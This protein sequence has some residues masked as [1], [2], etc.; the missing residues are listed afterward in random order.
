MTSDPEGLIPNRR[1]L[2]L[3]TSVVLNVLACGAPVC[4]LE[5]LQTRF[6]VP[7]QVVREI[8]KEPIGTDVPTDTFGELL[9]R[10]LLLEHRLEG[11][12]LRTFVELAAANPPDGLGD[13]EAAT[14][15]LAEDL[16][17]EAV[18]D[19]R[20]ATRIATFRR[21]HVPVLCTVDLFYDLHQ[22]LTARGH[23]VSDYVYKA[24]RDGRMRVPNRSGDWVV[25]LIGIKRA[26]QCP[27]LSSIVRSRND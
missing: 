6:I 8:S 5:S 7:S 14:I 25:N 18:I 9:R 24:L 11:D 23:D 27:S 26:R 17:C 16:G 12:A 1:I 19:E 21:S 20:K 13:G 2:V 4:A 15:A 3:D 10:E 22:R